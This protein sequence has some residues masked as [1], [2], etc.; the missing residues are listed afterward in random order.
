MEQPSNPDSTKIEEVSPIPTAATAAPTPTTEVKDMDQKVE[1]KAEASGSTTPA[2]V[3]AGDESSKATAVDSGDEASKG[4]VSGSSDEEEAKGAYDMPLVM[5]GR[6]Q[7]TQVQV[8][9]IDSSFA[10]KKELVIPQGMGKKLG[11]IAIVYDNLS[12]VKAEQL[13][14]LHRILYNRAGNKLKVKGN[15]RDF[16]GFVFA[17]EAEEEKKAEQL[18]H[19]KNIELKNI[20]G[21]MDL[22][23]GGTKTDLV[24]TILEFLKKPKGSSETLKKGKKKVASGSKKSSSK[25]SGSNTAKRSAP[26][27][28]TVAGPKKKAK[29]M[30][31]AK[32]SNSDGGSDDSGSDSSSDEDAPLIKTESIEDKIKRDVHEI[33]SKTTDL[34]TLTKRTV[35]DQL[36]KIH[37]DLVSKKSFISQ[38]IADE[39]Q[40]LD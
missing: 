37:G 18:F 27:S 24:N 21:Y 11:D 23:K 19:A 38:C 31:K 14:T 13:K 15:I 7:R 33:I 16:S 12:K 10:E 35:R 34:S 40:N 8:L 1:T 5:S 22:P 20:A 25:K 32:V 29:L 6:R 2:S 3:E 36:E 17:S 28:S 30:S 4:S 26:K 39:L 9:E